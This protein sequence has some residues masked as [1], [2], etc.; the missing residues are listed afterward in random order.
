ME[1]REELGATSRAS[2]LGAAS[3]GLRVRRGNAL[4]PGG[5]AEGQGYLTVEMGLESHRAAAWRWEA[6]RAVHRLLG[7]RKAGAGVPAGRGREVA[8]PGGRRVVERRARRA[9]RPGG[10]RRAEQGDD[11][12]RLRRRRPPHP[13]AAGAA[14][15]HGAGAARRRRVGGPG[16]CPRGGRPA[17]DGRGCRADGA[18][19]RSPPR[20]R[21]RRRTPVAPPR[22]RPT[23]RLLPPQ[24]D[25]DAELRASGATTPAPADNGE[26]E[27]IHVRRHP[28]AHSSASS[29]SS[30]SSGSSPLAHTHRATAPHRRSTCSTISPA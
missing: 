21:R 8:R 9:A 27:S 15:A 11:R 7:R 17:S 1:E 3:H 2:L 13:P 26:T 22:G 25:I 28:P 18:P 29:A 5:Q 23:H 12:N 19:P 24:A 14:Q 6:E 16:H 30:A 20:P 4:V 10:L